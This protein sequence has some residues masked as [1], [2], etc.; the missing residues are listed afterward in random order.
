MSEPT[1]SIVV[2]GDPLEIAPG[3][4][5]LGLLEALDRDPRT[6]A[7]E[8]N[9]EVL[10]RRVFAEVELGAG[11]RIEVVRFVQGGAA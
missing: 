5:V 9:G 4:T 10:P 2:N 3:S 8:L 7:I 11:D 1:C 6:V